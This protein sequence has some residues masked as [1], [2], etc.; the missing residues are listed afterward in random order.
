MTNIEEDYIP[1]TTI[2]YQFVQSIVH[3]TDK[4]IDELVKP[5]HDKIENLAKNQE[6][7]LKALKADVNSENPYKR[8]LAIYPELLREAYTRDTLKDIKTRWLLDAKSGKIYCENKRLFAIPDMYAICE[9]LFLHDP[10]PKGLLKA[11]QVGAKCLRN[12]GEMDF[13]R[14]PSLSMEHW[15]ATVVPDQEVYNWFYTNGCYMNCHDS[16]IK[17]LQGDVDGDT[18]NCVY[19]RVIVAAAKR[20]LEIQDVRTLNYDLGKASDKPVNNEEMFN[21]LKRAHEY[22]GIGQVSNNITKIWN[23]CKPD[24]DVTKLLCKYNNEVIDGAKSGKINDIEQYPDVRK[25]LNKAVG[26]KKSRMPAWFAF[27]KNA[28]KELHLAVKDRNKYAKENDS[29]MNRICRRFDDIGNI[30]FGK[31]NVPPFNWQMLLTNNDAIYDIAAVNTFCQL[32][33]GNKSNFAILS[34]ADITAEEAEDV[35]GYEFVKETIIDELTKNGKT[36]EEVYPSIVKYLFVG[37]NLNRPSHK[38][39]FW[40][41]FGEIAYRNLAENIETYTVCDKCGAKIPAWA[42][43]HDCPKNMAGFYECVDCGAW[44]S[45]TK[46]N[47]IRCE[48]CQTEFRAVSER[49][50]QMRRYVPRKKV[51]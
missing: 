46:N 4:E 38:Q 3:M 36:L 35:I 44:C 42:K 5:T 15:I 50:R 9:Y 11:H 6:S 30:N 33:D 43:T 16:M 20:E 37:Q 17:R 18:I 25:R 13:L 22:S 45:R 41:V 31:A 47:Q 32:D 23:S 28:R 1:D 39:M 51:S 2:N 40:R 14:S 10:D 29:T 26:G 34:T 8:S 27:S 24:Y 12:K 48:N 19:N 7:M 49:A 21:G